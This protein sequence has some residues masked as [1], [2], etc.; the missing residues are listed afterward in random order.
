MLEG[1]Y[2]YRFNHNANE[3]RRIRMALYTAVPG[4]LAYAIRDGI[5]I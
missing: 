4:I 3:R 5:P 2:R 1:A